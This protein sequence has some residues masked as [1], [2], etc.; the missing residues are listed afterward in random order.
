MRVTEAE[1]RERRRALDVIYFRQILISAAFGN[2]FP[3]EDEVLEAL[4]IIYEHELG[5]SIEVAK[6][7]GVD[8]STLYRRRQKR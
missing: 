4:E 1:W 3:T 7:L 6:A 5:S 2:W 8:A